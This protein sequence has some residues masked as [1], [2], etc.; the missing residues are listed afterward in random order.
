L[1]GV[2]GLTVAAAVLGLAEPWPLAV[3]LNEVLR[4]D[5]PSGIVRSIFGAHPTTWVVLVTMVGARFALIVAGNGVTVL[6]HYLGAKTEQNMVLDL[7]SDLF[8]HAQRLSFTFHDRRK[9]GELM[10]QINLQ[11]A[12]VGTIV[13]V[14]PPIAEALL[15]LVGMFAIAMLIDWQIAL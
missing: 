13:M 7:R 9:T 11:A 15:T 10:S 5:H 14:I 8:E 1:A 12:A 4:S 3:I 2:V 6:A